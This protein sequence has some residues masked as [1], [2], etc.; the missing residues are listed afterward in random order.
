MLFEDYLRNPDPHGWI[1]VAGITSRSEKDS[2][3]F[4]A[5][6]ASPSSA[7]DL[8]KTLEHEVNPTWFG[9]PT[10]A[11]SDNDVSFELRN[12]Y[13]KGS[14]LLEPF[15]IKRIFHGTRPDTYEV[16]QDFV[17]YHDL[18]FDHERDA[19]VDL[20]GDEIVRF[21]RLHMQVRED[22]LRDYLAARDRILVL[23]YD[24]RRQ[25]DVDVAEV[26]GEESLG[27]AGDRKGIRYSLKPS[28]N[29]DGP[30]SCF[31]GKRIVR[32]YPE[33]SHRD[34][35]SAADKPEK[36]ATYECEQDGE[37]AKKNC[38]IESGRQPGPFLTHVFF[39]KEVLSK[40]HDS[41]LYGVTDNT[42]WYLDFWSLEFGYNGELV[43]AW[44]GDLGRIPYDE[45]LHWKQYN[46][47][48]RGGMSGKFV[49]GEL[50]AE[51]TENKSSCDFL[52]A[53]KPK[54]NAS[55]KRRF[56]FDL[57]KETLP[58]KNSIGLH[59]LASDEEREFDEQIL[60]M[61]K[62]FVD[63]INVPDLKCKTKPTKNGSIYLL[64]QF[65][66]EAGMDPGRAERIAGAFHAVQSLRNGAAHLKG[67]VRSMFPG[68][69][70]LGPKERF[71]KIVAGFGCQ[72]V[73]LG[74]WLELNQSRLSRDPAS[75]TDKT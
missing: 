20:A 52:L 17:L 50:F 45:Q 58:D 15:V 29:L 12:R 51:F 55:F 43:H 16:V 7:D 73:D 2:R 30:I 41:S 68:L 19:Y 24:H 34:Y 36:Y 48:P 57:F 39:K 71:E 14:V 63:G 10:F 38:D 21:E 5:A 44:L 56:G 47:M 62:I 9:I 74:T 60:N 67:G 1:T 28:R 26:F 6:L 27:I 72:L 18:F 25:R 13:E 46:V 65:L 37:Y 33:P 32:P 42:V 61:A 3:F 49:R 54:A 4:F 40:Y 59:D 66:A 31:C 11:G 70:K 53:I 8:L 69:E 64:R 75:Q 22:S 23:Y 35:L